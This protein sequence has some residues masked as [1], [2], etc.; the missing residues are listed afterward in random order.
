MK[1]TWVKNKRGE[2]KEDE[3]NIPLVPLSDP[4]RRCRGS[5]SCAGKEMLLSGK[6]SHKGD[7]S[8]SCKCSCSQGVPQKKSVSPR[9]QPT[10]A[11][12]MGLMFLNRFF[13]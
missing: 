10:R 2:C 12:S 6:L 5:W 9:A 4:R 13:T 3:I 11:V 1:T 8:R 7:G